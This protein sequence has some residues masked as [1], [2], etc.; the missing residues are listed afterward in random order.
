MLSRLRDAERETYLDG[1]TREQRSFARGLML[2][3]W[4]PKPRADYLL[5]LGEKNRVERDEA[6]VHSH[7]NKPD[8]MTLYITLRIVL[9]YI[10]NHHRMHSTSGKITGAVFFTR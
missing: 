1:L 7:T 8:Y 9:K 4:Q 3:Q 6:E 2:H 5:W 10:E